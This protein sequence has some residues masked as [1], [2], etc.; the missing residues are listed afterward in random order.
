DSQ[1]P[2]QSSTRMLRLFDNGGQ[3]LV[4]TSD[5]TKEATLTLTV[6]F[7]D[8]SLATADR[9][10]GF[11]AQ[12][13][14]WQQMT[15]LWTSGPSGKVT[16]AG[17]G[18]AIL[19]LLLMLTMLAARAAR[20]E[21]EPAV[22]TAAETEI[23]ALT[24]AAEGTGLTYGFLDLQD[25]DGPPR[26]EPITST[27]F[28]IGRSDTNDLVLEN[29]TVSNDHAVVTV[30]QNNA[31]EIRDIHSANGTHVNGHRTGR[32][33]LNDGDIIEIGRVRMKFVMRA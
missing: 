15:N 5:E 10:L 8:G 9:L 30:D 13:T 6:A 1:I 21:P 2:E 4:D 20:T 11:T 23:E 18:L 24:T 7:A 19:A 28:R 32:A 14:I 3:V 33:F 26:R 17:G 31:F 25:G 12:P 27:S 22:V 16:I 29:S